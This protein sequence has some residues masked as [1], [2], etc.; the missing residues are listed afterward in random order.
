[1]NIPTLL[2]D[3]Q[4]CRANIRRMAEKARVNNL[5]FR[6]HFK[7]HQSHLIG[8]WFREEGVT[9][10]TVSSLR[11]ASYFAEDGWNDITVAFPVNIREM[12]TINA[13]AERITLNLLVESEEAVQALVFG[14]RHPVNVFIKIDIGTHRTGIDPTHTSHIQT[15]ISAIYQAEKLDF[16]GFLCHAGHSYQARG[17][18]AILD[19]HAAS[20]KLIETLRRSFA[21][22]P[23]LFITTGDTPTC[24][25]A[26]SFPGVNEIRPGNFVFYDIMQQQIGSCG[27]SDIGVAV[28]CPVVAKHPERNELVIYGGGVHFSKDFIEEAGHRVF[29]H[30]V[31]PTS[32]GWADTLANAYVSKLSQEHGVISAPAEWINTQRI[33]DLV[34]VLPVHSCMTMDLMRSFEVV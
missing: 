30:V 19:V 8:Q 25:I 6:P 20:M 24:S 28:A 4:K 1:M 2:V 7:T 13:L 32:S 15:L 16:A 33:G 14:L 9:K 21:D 34:Y 5:I 22:I 29:G 26:N 18:S 31:L 3:E 17:T 23:D 10:I 12:D 27:A 11:M